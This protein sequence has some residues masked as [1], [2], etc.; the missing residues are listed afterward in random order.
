MSGCQEFAERN[1]QSIDGLMSSES[2]LRDI[3]MMDICGHT[4]SRP[5]DYATLL[6][7]LKWTL[8]KKKIKWTLRWTGDVLIMRQCSHPWSKNKKKRCHSVDNGCFTWGEYGEFLYIPVQFYCKPAAAAAK[9]LQSCPALC[10]P[11]DGSLPGIPVPGILQARTLEWIAIS[12]SNGWKWKM[13][14]KSLSHVGLVATPWSAAYQAPPS[15]GFPR[16]EYW[17]RV[18]LPSPY[19]KPKT[20]LK[21][22]KGLQKKNLT[23]DRHFWQNFFLLLCMHTYYI[24]VFVGLWYKIL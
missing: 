20:A 10:N 8:K 21:K 17:S 15:M 19:C 3:T 13:K 24:C 7:S 6:C 12:F 18:P 22:E 2:A 4:L 14:V 23:Q 1:I 5:T 11:I 9:S 16:Q